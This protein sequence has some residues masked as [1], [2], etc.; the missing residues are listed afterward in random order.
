MELSFVR[1]DCSWGRHSIK[2]VPLDFNDG[3]QTWNKTMDTLYN[4]LY[5]ILGGDEVYQG[6]G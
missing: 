5:G 1:H 2:F 4:T 3:R 6:R